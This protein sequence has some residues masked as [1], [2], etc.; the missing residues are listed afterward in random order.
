M[1]G[2]VCL[3]LL[4]GVAL[5]VTACI[6]LGSPDPAQGTIAGAIGTPVAAASEARDLIAAS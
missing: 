3:S 6:A 2:L 1:R 4:I 5:S